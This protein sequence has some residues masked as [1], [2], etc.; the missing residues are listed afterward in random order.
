MSTARSAAARSEGQQLNLGGVIKYVNGPA[1]ASASAAIGYYSADGMRFDTAGLAPEAYE[2]RQESV[3]LSG[4][5]RLARLFSAGALDVIPLI[6]LDGSL[7]HD[8]GY[9]E[10]GPGGQALRVHAH[11]QFLLDV[12]PAIRFGTE[13]S[14]GDVIFRPHVAVG[15]RLALTDG[16]VR[17]SLLGGGR[18]SSRPVSYTHERDDVAASFELGLRAFARERWEVSAVYES[19]RGAD[20]RSDNGSVKIAWRF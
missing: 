1:L 9:R 12:H 7:V 18:F 5:L 4:R 8:F 15:A 13:T 19:Y 20:S 10:Q 3:S 14:I 11:S 17:Q 16:R 6:D 2:F